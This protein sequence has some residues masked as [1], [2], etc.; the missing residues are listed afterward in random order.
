MTIE[1]YL[2]SLNQKT[3]KSIKLNFG[4]TTSINKSIMYAN[5]EDPRSCDRDLGALKPR[6]KRQFLAQKLLIRL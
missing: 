4:Y 2:I 5:F 3:V 6:K 1:T